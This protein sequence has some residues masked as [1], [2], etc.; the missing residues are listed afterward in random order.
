MSSGRTLRSMRRE[1]IGERGEDVVVGG[2]RSI[3]RSRSGC[4]GR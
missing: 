3:C 2:V 4:E 1:K